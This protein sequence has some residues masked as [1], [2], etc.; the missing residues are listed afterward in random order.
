MSGGAFVFAG[1]H[2]DS[3]QRH[4]VRLRRSASGNSSNISSEPVAVPQGE[5]GAVC[6]LS[7][8]LPALVFDWFNSALLGGG[9]GGW[10]WVGPWTTGGSTAAVVLRFFAPFFIRSQSPT[11]TPCLGLAWGVTFAFR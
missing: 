3:L 2:G 11:H 8:R 6:R 10:W 5:S 1:A 9:G 7:S 4:T